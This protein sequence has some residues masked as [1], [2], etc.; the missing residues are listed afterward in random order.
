VTRRPRPGTPSTALQG[1]ALLLLCQWPASCWRARWACRCRARCWACCLV[2]A[3]LAC[4]G[5]RGARRWQPAA[6]A[7]LA[8]LSL[9]FV[10]V[11]VGVVT[12]LGLWRSTAWRWR[13]CCCCPPGSG[14]R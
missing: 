7:L 6:E 8:H 9:L 1:L 5:G 13:W 12:H 4:R 14:W 2:L 3:L 10:P 11:G